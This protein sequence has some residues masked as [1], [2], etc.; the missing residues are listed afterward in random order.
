MSPQQTIEVNDLDLRFENTRRCDP[1]AQRRLLTSIMERDILDPLVVSRCSETGKSVLLDGFKR[2]RC[3]QK[4]KK[5]IVSVVYIGEDL[6]DGV[7]CFLRREQSV[8]LGILEQAGLIED[9]HKR[10]HLSIQEIARRLERSPAWVSVRLSLLSEMSDLIR[11]KIM[12]GAFPARAY[13]YG[14]RV[15]TRV[16]KA[17]NRQADAF[18][19]AVSG[20]G[21][22]TRELTVLSRAYFTG[23]TT[24]ERMITEGDAHHVLKLIAAQGVARTDTTL[25]AQEQL[26]VNNL[27]TIAGVMG[28]VITCA[29]SMNSGTARCM[30]HINTWSGSIVQSLAVF[31]QTIKEL[32][33]YSGPKNHRTH[34]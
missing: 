13:M 9:L 16:H 30:Q 31:T 17:N 11:N 27:K 3:A 32:H 2:Y 10:Q 20:K 14:L 1:A 23:G 24:M 28:Q 22:S 8:P 33:D 21:L 5:N 18:V 7:L 29:P 19:T 26:F 25:S 15:F 4:L 6:T 12:S 34:P